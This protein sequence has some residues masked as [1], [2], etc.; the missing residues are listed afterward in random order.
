[1]FTTNRCSLV[2]YGA[3]ASVI[4][5]VPHPARATDEPPVE[6]ADGTPQG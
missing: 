4:G 5:A 2:K 3:M 6:K 1:M